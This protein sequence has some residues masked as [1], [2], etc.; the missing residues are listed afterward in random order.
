MS[1]DAREVD[2]GLGDEPTNPATAPE[3]DYVTAIKTALP[4]LAN[5]YQQDQLNRL[6]IQRMSKGLPPI[7]GAEY[8]QTYAMPTAQVQVD[9][10]TQVRNLM[11][12][13]GVVI[14][15]SALVMR[16]GRR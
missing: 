3:A 7:S 9:A 15:V 6:N 4:I 8:A 1:R 2:W 12:F 5:V 14:V 16:H 10:S 13:G 11:I